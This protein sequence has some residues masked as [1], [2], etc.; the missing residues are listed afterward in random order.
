MDSTNQ[1]SVTNERYP[2]SGDSLEREMHVET[3]DIKVHCMLQLVMSWVGGYV[4]DVQCVVVESV[5]GVLTL[6]FVPAILHTVHIRLICC[7]SC[8]SLAYHQN[9]DLQSFVFKNTIREEAQTC[10]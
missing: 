10:R 2:S 1:N 5:H 7:L 3:K 4:V 6:H 8:F 9:Q